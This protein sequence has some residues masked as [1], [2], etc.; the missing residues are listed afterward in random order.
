[1]FAFF[2]VNMF[3]YLIEN[4]DDF[5]SSYPFFLAF[6]QYYLQQLSYRL[7]FGLEYKTCAN[8]RILFDSLV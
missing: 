8:T 2:F 1:M 7:A 6:H 4:M 5:S 3:M